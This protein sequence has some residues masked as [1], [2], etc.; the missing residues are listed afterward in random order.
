MVPSAHQPEIYT[1]LYDG[2]LVYR[3]WSAG[4]AT[5]GRGVFPQRGA[6]DVYVDLPVDFVPAIGDSP[7]C[8]RAFL[9]PSIVARLLAGRTFEG[10][11]RRRVVVAL[12]VSIVVSPTTGALTSGS[13]DL[14]RVLPG[15]GRRRPGL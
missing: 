1:A 7:P 8:S 9:A 2:F 10:G 3:W 5:A 11:F 15:G 14:V 4:Q 12:W 13:V 6:A